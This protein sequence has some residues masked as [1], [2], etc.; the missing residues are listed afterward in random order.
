MGLFKKRKP[1]Y[2]QGHYNNL[3]LIPDPQPD[4]KTPA[5]EHDKEIAYNNLDIIMPTKGQEYMTAEK[6]SENIENIQIQDSEIPVNKETDIEKPLKVQND[7]IP[8]YGEELP[9]Y[10]SPT[11]ELFEGNVT[12]ASME[13]DDSIITGMD[14]P[15]GLTKMSNNEQSIAASP[16]MTDK[17]PLES[18]EVNYREQIIKSSGNLTSTTQSNVVSNIFLNT[19]MNKLCNDA[20]SKKS[21]TPSMKKGPELSLAEKL[22]QNHEVSLTPKSKKKRC[23]FLGHSCSSCEGFI[24]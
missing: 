16:V 10:E 2:R 19:D 5:L 3:T 21:S 14:F 9:G 18:T 12:E 1:L 7:Q 20:N 8:L 4:N 13:H 23:D 17:F 24:C 15:I 11:Q 6:K 22:K